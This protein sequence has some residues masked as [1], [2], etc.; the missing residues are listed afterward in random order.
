MSNNLSGT[1]QTCIS[2]DA[3]YVTLESIWAVVALV[4]VLQAL[5]D[6]FQSEALNNM[7]NSQIQQV[8]QPF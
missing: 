3:L 7:I 8:V 1:L 6:G 4:T 2:A 5:H